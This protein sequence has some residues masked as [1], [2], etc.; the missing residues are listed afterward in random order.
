MLGA[1]R[2]A[3]AA[4]ARSAGGASFGR[5]ANPR[6]SAP[7][8]PPRRTFRSSG[9]R[10]E[11]QRSDGGS[12]NQE[13]WREASEEAAETGNKAMKVI[14]AGLLAPLALYVPYALAADIFQV[15]F[16]L[17]ELLKQKELDTPDDFYGREEEMR[18]MRALFN[19]RPD[20]ICILTG[21]SDSGKSSLMNRVLSGRR[22]LVKMDLREHSV[23]T[24]NDFVRYFVNCIRAEFIR[25]RTWLVDLLPVYGAENW[26]MK[27]R[28]KVY[29]LE[30]ALKCL[31]AALV[32]GRKQ[33]P[34]EV[35]VI[36]IDEFGS[37]LDLADSSEGKQLVQAIL[38]W[39][40]HVTKE[41]QLTHVVLGSSDSFILEKLNDF[42]GL[43][44]RLRYLKVGDL[45]A[46]AARDFL[47]RSLSGVP[48]VTESHVDRIVGTV[49][50][51]L[52]DLRSTVA[53]VKAKGAGALDE[54]LD[55]IFCAQ[56]NRI[57]VALAAKAV[58]PSPVAAPEDDDGDDGDDDDDDDDDG[59]DDDDDGEE[60]AKPAGRAW[61]PAQL[62]DS[63]KAVAESEHG[64]VQYHTLK[65]EVFEGDDAAL[66]ALVGAD[67]LGFRAGR[68]PD[69]VAAT[70][71]GLDSYYITAD[72]PLVHNVF[73][74][75]LADEGVQ[76]TVKASSQEAKEK[77][78]GRERERGE[79]DAADALALIAKEKQ[80]LLTHF[81][82]LEKLDDFM[83]P[84][85]KEERVRMLLRKEASIFAREA[86]LRPAAAS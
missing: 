62:W 17:A 42:K 75:L 57:L 68:S 59:D 46:D 28:L 49:G 81:D 27:Y 25:V 26:E 58:G 38:T 14:T 24:V 29:D 47:A 84:E 79:R 73:K 77:S 52:L 21:P 19:E 53:E 69:L 32:K 78:E 9:S 36:F 41:L 51:R 54:I 50:G 65:M 72:S 16:C 13:G 86:A 44:G 74:E 11:K 31:T 3:F 12:G 1:A 70:K 63:M 83:T 30:Q 37:L 56:R 66:K 18:M 67:I 48:G 71:G 20:R 82:V 35:P 64:Y 33:H 85:E 43:N 8:V 7:G 6:S 15:D 39:A 4:A 23:H 34:N 10:Q 40:V 5:H 60:A 61:T 22:L 45:T 76:E 80:R 55:S 2:R